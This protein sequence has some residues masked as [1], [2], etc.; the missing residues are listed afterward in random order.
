MAGVVAMME[1]VLGDERS[2]IGVFL[3]DGGDGFVEL[4]RLECDLELLT[5]SA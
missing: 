4:A 5:A 2:S 3:E 1:L